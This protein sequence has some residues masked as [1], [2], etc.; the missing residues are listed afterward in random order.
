[1]HT[2]S[3]TGPRLYF[4][5]SIMATQRLAA[6]LKISVLLY[7]PIGVKLQWVKLAMVLLYVVYFT[8]I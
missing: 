3:Y 6:I 4:F 2:N 1:M 8:I 5:I 7:S